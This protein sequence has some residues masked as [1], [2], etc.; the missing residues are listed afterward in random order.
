[1]ISR[2]TTTPTQV[3]NNFESGS[4]KLKFFQVLEITTIIIA[5]NLL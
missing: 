1:M 5:C 4:E 3:R 2:G